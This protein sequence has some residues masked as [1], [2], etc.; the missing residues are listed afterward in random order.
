MLAK[1]HICM[2]KN[3]IGFFY[4][5]LLWVFVLILGCGIAN[6]EN[7]NNAR[8]LTIACLGHCIETAN[9]VSQAITYV[10][11]ETEGSF[12]GFQ[13]FMVDSLNVNNENNIMDK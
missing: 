8:I 11:D 4:K 5:A 10:R 2:T 7:H 6:T 1:H 13:S 3:H 12:L 9:D